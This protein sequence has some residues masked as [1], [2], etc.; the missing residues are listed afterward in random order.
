M[1]EGRKERKGRLE[2]KGKGEIRMK[3]RALILE[4]IPYPATPTMHFSSDSYAGIMGAGGSGSGGDGD[5][6]LKTRR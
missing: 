1:P 6:G 5:A 2:A 4:T 3:H